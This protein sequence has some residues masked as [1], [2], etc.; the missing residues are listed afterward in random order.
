[1]AKTPTT[2]PRSPDRI[3]RLLNAKKLVPKDLRGTDRYLDVVSWNIRFFDHKDPH[4]VSYIIDVMSAINADMFVLTEIAADGAM[5]AVIEG[6]A[7][8]RAGFYSAF[9]GSKGG[10]QR[11][12]MMW[13]RDWVRAKTDLSEL[14]SDAGTV[15]AEDGTQKQVFDRLP[16]YGYFEALAEKPGEEGFTFELVGVHLKSQRPPNGWKG[17]GR[18][19]VKQRTAAAKRI[20]AWLTDL[21]IHADEDTII[22]GD[23]NAGADLPEWDALRKLE[24]KGTVEFESINPSGEP[25]YLARLGTTASGSRLDLQLINKP[26][27]A[28]AVQDAKG[29]VIRWSFLDELAGLPAADRARLSALMRAQL[30]DHMPVVTRFYFTDPRGDRP[31]GG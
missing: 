23:W 10:Q 19:G 16:V 3:S 30:S 14:F 2:A 12:V 27:D 6:L 5:D 25:S 22:I 9:T 1:M 8:R 15:Q 24:Q 31:A 13:D 28:V 4:R 29:V 17:D 26:A 18:F 7:K 20:A 21:S 11:V